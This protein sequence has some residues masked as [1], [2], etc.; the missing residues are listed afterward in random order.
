MRLVSLFAALALSFNVMASTGSDEPKN[1]DKDRYCAKLKDGKMTVFYE[2][3]TL[4]GTVTLTNGTQILT[5]G[6][7]IKKDGTKVMLKEGECVNKEGAI[8]APS[9]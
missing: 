3:N 9:K 4:T 7:V 1:K 6:T 2:N 8:E 5:D